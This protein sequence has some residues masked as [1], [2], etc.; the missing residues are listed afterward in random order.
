MN[1]KK[2]KNPVKQLAVQLS[3]QMDSEREMLSPYEREE[4]KE[5]GNQ[6]RDEIFKKKYDITQVMYYVEEYKSLSIE[7][8]FKWIYE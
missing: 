1:Q 7:E 5:Y 2:E 6:L 8:Y 3:R 4:L